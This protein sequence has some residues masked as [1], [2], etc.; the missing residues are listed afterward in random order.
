MSRTWFRFASAAALLASVVFAA[1]AFA[2]EEVPPPQGKGRVVVFVSGLGGPGHDKGL[3]D[4]IAALGYDV[5]VYDGRKF[6]EGMG[7]ALRDDIQQ[8]QQMPHALPGKVALVGVSFGGGFA[9]AH[10]VRWADLVAVE[11]VWYPAT[12]FALKI[13][14]FVGRIRVPVLMFA[15]ESDRFQNCCLIGTARSLAADAAV[16]KAPFELVTYP[17]ADHD[18]IRGGRNYNPAAYQDAFARTAARLKAAFAD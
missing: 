11:I 18:F 9:L 17:G 15:G 2:Q 7:E 13:P 6:G 10:G 5:V 14:D 1:S 8:A 12:R 16:V 3:V 4:D